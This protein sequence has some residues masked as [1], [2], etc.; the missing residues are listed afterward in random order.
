[1]HNFAPIPCR[2]LVLTVFLFCNHDNALAPFCLRGV[3]YFI[4]SIQLPRR[5]LCNCF[6]H[7]TILVIHGEVWTTYVPHCIG[8]D[9]HIASAEPQ[10]RPVKLYGCT[11]KTQGTQSSVNAQSNSSWHGAWWRKTSLIIRWCMRQK[12]PAHLYHYLWNDTSLSFLN[13]VLQFRHS[14][15]KLRG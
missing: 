6:E 2:P 11:R 8:Y 3:T 12:R 13:I 1:M 7:V 10:R 9:I 4:I 14:R 5:S 15:F